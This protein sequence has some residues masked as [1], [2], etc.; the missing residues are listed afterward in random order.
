MSDDNTDS[1]VTLPDDWSVWR[2]NFASF[3]S[4]KTWVQVWL[5]LLHALFVAALAF[6]E[7]P[8]ARWILIGWL[9]SMPLIGV[10]MVVQRG[11]TRLLAVA[12]LIPWT[13]LWVYLV[14]R[15]TTDVA[16]PRVAAAQEP[17]LFGYLVAMVVALG[18][19]LAFDVIDTIRWIRGERYVMGSEWAVEVGASRPADGLG[20][21][22]QGRRPARPTGD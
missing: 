17:A 19:C 16:G 3:R 9:A 5:V 12:H 15:L 10:F 21:D 1:C 6:V 20:G 18:V 4:M 22:R 8:S 11:L 13:P 14:L 2:A 7:Y